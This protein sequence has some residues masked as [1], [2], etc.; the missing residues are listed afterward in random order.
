MNLLCTMYHKVFCM[1]AHLELSLQGSGEHWSGSLSSVQTPSPPHGCSWTPAIAH[2]HT[3]T[4]A[5]EA[6]E[7][8]IEW[9]LINALPN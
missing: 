5:D 1:L 8:A 4:A 7:L 9:S 3:H 2:T 6:I